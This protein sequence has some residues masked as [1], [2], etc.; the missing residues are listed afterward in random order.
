MPLSRN[1]WRVTACLAFLTLA[2]PAF[3]RAETRIDFDDFRPRDG[4][5]VLDFSLRGALDSKKLDTIH[6]GI[7]T[8]VTYEVS[9][10]RA[11][12]GWFD[13][14]EASLTFA[15]SVRFDVVQERYVIQQ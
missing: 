11:R 4:W 14:V 12:S 2:L 15:V 9:L 10:L 5:L 1:G 3:A 6:R 8:T 13:K 7:P